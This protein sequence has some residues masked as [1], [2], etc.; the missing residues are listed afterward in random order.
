MKSC[1]SLTLTLAILLICQNLSAQTYHY[2][3]SHDTLGN[4]LSRVYQGTIPAKGDNTL[5]STVDSKVNETD[6]ATDNDVHNDNPTPVAPAGKDTTIYNPP[7]KTP[8]EKVAYLQAMMD[9]VMQMWPIPVSGDRGAIPNHS[10][11]EI[12]LSY[13]ISGSGART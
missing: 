5:S 2:T 10:V 8:A 12:P 6:F 13:G 4:R 3:F 11:G 9:E 7:A 1:H